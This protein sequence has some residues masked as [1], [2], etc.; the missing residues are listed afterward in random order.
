M[1]AMMRL[2]II[3]CFIGVLAVGVSGLHFDCT[4]TDLRE[5][6]RRAELEKKQK[7]TLARL[8]ARTQV[9]RDLIA[10]RYTLAE[11]IEQFL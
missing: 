1:Y 8:E 2:L 4:L 7:A 5:A 9:V 6:N 11:A 3:G 10:Q